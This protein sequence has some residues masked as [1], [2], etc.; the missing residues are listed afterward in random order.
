MNEN[1]RVVSNNY[2]AFNETVK[3]SK[4]NCKFRT[5]FYPLPV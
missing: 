1:G 3:D 5:Y 4:I 2:I